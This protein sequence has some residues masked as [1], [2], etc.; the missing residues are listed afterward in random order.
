MGERQ[1]VYEFVGGSD[2]FLGLAM[3]QWSWNGPVTSIDES[4][5]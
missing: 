1:S 5:G 4:S 2:A 3:P